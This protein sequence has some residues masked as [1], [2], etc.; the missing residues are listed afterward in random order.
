MAIQTI[1]NKTVSAFQT[2]SSFL[3]DLLSKCKT[4]I[5][6][7]MHSGSDGLRRHIF[8]ALNISVISLAM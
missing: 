5:L 7:E 3:P 2:E 4:W 6:A 8:V 1:T